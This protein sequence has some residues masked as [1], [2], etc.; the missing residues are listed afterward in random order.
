MT[1]LPAPP[2]VSLRTRPLWRVRL[3][4]SITRWLICAAVVIAVLAAIRSAL[5]PAATA[6]GRDHLGSSAAVVSPGL[7][8]AH[9]GWAADA[10]GWWAPGRLRGVGSDR[11]AASVTQARL[12]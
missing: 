2:R 12:P 11:G 4:L 5:V 9:P 3:T 7:G 8:G 6:S 10:A 1:Q